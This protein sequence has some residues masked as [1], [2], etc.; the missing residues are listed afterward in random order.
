VNSAERSR[1]GHHNLPKRERSE[2]HWFSPKTCGRAKVQI[3]IRGSVDV[4]LGWKRMLEGL[5]TAADIKLT[6]RLLPH[7]TIEI[8]ADLEDKVAVGCLNVLNAR[9][10]RSPLDDLRGQVLRHRRDFPCDNP[11]TC[12][13]ASHL[14]IVEIPKGNVACSS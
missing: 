9:T 11:L 14:E 10:L 5:T 12:Q 4:V 13:Q 1:P 3:T 6:D 7:G 2:V 8:S